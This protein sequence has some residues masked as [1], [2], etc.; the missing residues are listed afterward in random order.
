MRFMIEYILIRL[1]KGVALRALPRSLNH[2][3]II[4]SSTIYS[5]PQA[6]IAACALFLFQVILK[7]KLLGSYWEALLYSSLA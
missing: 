5:L 7:F 4:I 3:L 6:A 1:S 2:W